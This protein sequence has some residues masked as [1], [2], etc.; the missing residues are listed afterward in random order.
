MVKE[1]PVNRDCMVVVGDW[2]WELSLPGGF[3]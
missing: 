1:F 2:E 3:S